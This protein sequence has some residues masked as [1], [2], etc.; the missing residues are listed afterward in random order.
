MSVSSTVDV[1][2]TASELEALR[3]EWHKLWLLDPRA[4]PFQRPEWLLSWW[5]HFGQPILYVIRFLRGS[6]LTGILPLYVYV[7]P[8]HQES[9]LL[10]IGAGTSDYLD[11]IFSPVCTSADILHG[12]ASL[13]EE[14]TWD[15]AYLS[16]LLPT[17]P[18]YQALADRDATLF[19]RFSAEACSRCPASL[20]A[21][22]PKKVRADVRYFRNSAISRG[23]LHLH[24]A[25]AISWP[26]AFDRLAQ[27]HST[28]WNEVGMPGVLVDPR[29]LAWHREAIPLLLAADAVRLY[30]LSLEDVPVATLYALIDPPDRKDRTGYFYLIGHSQ[31]HADLKTGTLLTAMATEHAALEGVQ[32]I[33]MLRGNETYKNFWHVKEVPTF[34]FSFRRHG[35]AALTE[36]S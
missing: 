11:G 18:L 9:Q 1:L 3:P 35:L 26:S 33:D 5:H 32:I 34:G 30:T 2:R 8:V 7:D 25:D 14:T 13:A 31:A 23:K 27:Q 6:L 24:L 21:D 36:H 20:I 22:L 16:Q 4:K 28:R 17:S 29:V 15:V 10:L 19:H 12:L